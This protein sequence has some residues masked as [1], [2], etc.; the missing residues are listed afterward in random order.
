MKTWHIQTWGAGT[1]HFLVTAPTKEE[2]WEIVKKEWRKHMPT[3]E[4]GMDYY[5]RDKYQTID[6]LVEIEGLTSEKPII[7]D[8]RD[9][10]KKQKSNHLM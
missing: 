8:L 6:D 7:I 5:K 4:V 9:D 1:P 3:W 2:A 10:W